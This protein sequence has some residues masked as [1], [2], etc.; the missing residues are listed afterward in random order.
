M[1]VTDVARVCH[2]ANRAYCLSLGDES[3][4]AW[5][6][7]PEWQQHITIHGVRAILAGTVTTGAQAHQ[8]WVDEQTRD[9]WK[10]GAY[11]DAE[12]KWHPYLVPYA[13]LAA[14]QRAKDE[15]FVAIVRALESTLMILD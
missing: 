5:Q 6:Y 1:T 3:Q 10:Y 11:K 15:L 4:A 12:A 9:G 14:A 7:A 2:E 13:Q 8:A